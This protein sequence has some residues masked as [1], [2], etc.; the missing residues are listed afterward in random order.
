MLKP[1]ATS[2]REIVYRLRAD[3][4]SCVFAAIQLRLRRGRSLAIS[5]GRTQAKACGYQPT[6]DCLSTE[7]RPDVLRSRVH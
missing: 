2:Q 5:T 4:T 1:A 7:G 6:S 3:L